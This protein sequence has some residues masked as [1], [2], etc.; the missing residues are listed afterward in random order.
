MMGV[1]CYATLSLAILSHHLAFA[2]WP[3]LHFTENGTFQVT[4]F[5]DL[6]FGEAEDTDWGPLQDVDTLKVMR[7][8]LSNE[9]T[10]LVI[11]N[12]DLITGEN[13][14]KEN[15]TNYVDEIVA[16]LV[17]AGLPWASTY[18]SESRVPSHLGCYAFPVPVPVP[19]CQLISFL[20]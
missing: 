4:I 1:I 2:A 15:S 16:P 7:T 9:T 13:T 5:E 20:G 11:L 8:V 6:H 14:Y 17:E 19:T 10:Q 3:A 12:G 18:G